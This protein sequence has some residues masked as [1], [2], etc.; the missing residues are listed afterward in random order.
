[1]LVAESDK[2]SLRINGIQNLINK[3]IRNRR[4]LG[5]AYQEEE[6]FVIDIEGG[7]G[8]GAAAE[9]EVRL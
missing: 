1:M 4:D 2:Y 5:F 8:G 7:G 6:S 9:K 3:G